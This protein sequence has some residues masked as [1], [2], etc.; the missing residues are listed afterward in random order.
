MKNKNNMAVNFPDPNLEAIIRFKINKPTGDILESDLIVI[1]SLIAGFKDISNINGL[2]C[3]TALIYLSL[4][5]NSISDLSPLNGLIKLTELYL[6]GNLITDISP[7]SGLIKLT[8]LYLDNNKISDI[9]PLSGLTALTYLDLNYNDMEIKPDTTQGQ[10][11]LDVV[12]WHIDNGCYV[13]WKYGNKTENKGEIN[14]K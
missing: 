14:E 12:N 10:T 2:E 6:D 11:N 1:K 7:L 3:C 13:N 9:S 4:N 5:D 8:K